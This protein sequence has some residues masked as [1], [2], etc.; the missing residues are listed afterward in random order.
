[1]CETA[2]FQDA[3]DRVKP[4]RS[5]TGVPVY[6]FPVCGLVCC[7]ESRSLN[8]SRVNRRGYSRC[9]TGI[10]DYT[11]FERIASVNH[12]DSLN[13]FDNNNGKGLVSGM[14]YCYRVTAKYLAEGNFEL[15]EGYASNEVCARQQKD[16]PVITHVSIDKTSESSGIVWMDWSKPTELDTNLYKGPYKNVVLKSINGNPFQAYKV[17]NSATFY[18]LKDTLV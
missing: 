18:G 6:R 8:R 12:P 14:T 15:V 13:F 17:F 9:E 7:A 11:G 3:A 1:M 16:L 2:A 10:P 4:C 5:K